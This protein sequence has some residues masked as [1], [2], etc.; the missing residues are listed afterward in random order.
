MSAASEISSDLAIFIAQTWKSTPE[1]LLGYEQICRIW[2]Y[3]L[4]WFDI[5][6]SLHIRD[7]LI[8]AGW[9][10]TDGDHIQAEFD[11]EDVEIPFSW[12]PSMRV[13]ENPPPLEGVERIVPENSIPTAT[14]THE[15]S[16]E[17]ISGPV[18]LDPATAHIKPL[19]DLISNQSKIDTK[20]VLRRAQRKRRA[21]G[22]V[23][24]W[25][26][27][28]LVAREQRLTMTELIQRVS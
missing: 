5:N 3:D 2:A 4:G 20:E 6:T 12:M 9:L 11:F 14:D 18:S 7:R 16:S 19:L 22:P 23:T 21:L 25:M 1:N 10:K 8:E 24:L 17:D 15:K 26:A 27:L 13:L 28:L